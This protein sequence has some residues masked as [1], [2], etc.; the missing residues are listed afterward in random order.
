MGDLD[1]LR[2]ELGEVFRKA[3][4]AIKEFEL[5]PSDSISDPKSPG[6]DEPD[7]SALFIPAVNQLRY[8]GFH[9]VKADTLED[10][11][12]K[13]SNLRKAINHCQRAYFDT[14]EAM[15]LEQL[16]IFD[17]FE[18]AFGSSPSLIANYPDYAEDY[19]KVETIKKQITQIRKK[20]YSD[21]NDLFDEIDPHLEELRTIADRAAVLRPVLAAQDKKDSRAFLFKAWGLVVATIVAIVAVINLTKGTC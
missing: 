5:T 8:A 4:N 15:L 21:R 16:G 18:K 14:K 7:P 12:E 13:E 17:E 6:I 9:Y 19:S 20:V 1:A 3:E 11:E 2:K 10:A